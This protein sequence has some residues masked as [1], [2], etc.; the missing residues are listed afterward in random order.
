MGT[1]ASV[2]ARLTASYC[3]EAG[4]GG[5]DSAD[6]W[7]QHVR[8]GRGRVR[9]LGCRR[10]RAGEQRA[11]WAVDAWP[12]RGRKMGHCTGPNGEGQPG[13]SAAREGNAVAGLG[14]RGGKRARSG[15]WGKGKVGQRFGLPTGFGLVSLFFF[16]VFLSY[17]LFP[18]SKHYSNLIEF[19]FKFE[20]NPSTQTNKTML[21]QE[22]TNILTL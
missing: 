4:K 18:I 11:S 2:T 6:R 1:R 19:K 17:F 12:E 14:R 13:L 9:G 22:C 20:L 15:P 5:E 3:C 8:E 16:W 21:Q 10:A 7:G